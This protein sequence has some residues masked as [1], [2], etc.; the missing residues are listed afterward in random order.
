MKEVVRFYFEPIDDDEGC[1]NDVLAIVT[2]PEELEQ[3]NTAISEIQDSISAYLDSVPAWEFEKL[4]CDVLNASGF[5]YEIIEP[6][7]ICI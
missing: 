4:A 5:E 6:T 1:G 3:R 7:V 2:L